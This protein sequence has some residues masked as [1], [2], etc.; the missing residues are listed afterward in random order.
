ME[1]DIDYFEAQDESGNSYLKA[2]GFDEN[3]NEVCQ[4]YGCDKE[5]CNCIGYWYSGNEK[6]AVRWIERPNAT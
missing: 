2:V 3:D 5:G 6:E 4:Q 1:Y